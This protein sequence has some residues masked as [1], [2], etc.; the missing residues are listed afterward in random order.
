MRD[1]TILLVDD[2]RSLA[3]GLARLLGRDGH[4]VDV[5]ANGCLA[6]AKLDERV[7]DL[8]LSDI[9]MPELDGPGLYR[10]LQH[11]RPHLCQ[12]LI[13][14]TGDTLEPTTLAFLKASGVPCLTKPFTLN[15]VRHA[16]QHAVRPE[17]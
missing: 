6:L 1:L 12:R 14:L 4:T 10:I 11:Q 8:I 13:F 16:I 7:Y 9:R 17:S 5:V 3:Q 15:E 2:E